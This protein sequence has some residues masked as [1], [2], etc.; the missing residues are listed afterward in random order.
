MNAFQTYEAM[1]LLAMARFTLDFANCFRGPVACK[2][3][4][5]DRSTPSGAPAAKQP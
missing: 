1:M 4:P 3:R 2:Q 5:A